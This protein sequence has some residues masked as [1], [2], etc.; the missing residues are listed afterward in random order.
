MDK[1]KEKLTNLK[2]EAESWQE[3]YEELKEQM[4]QLEQDNIQKENEIKSLTVKNQQL[5]QEVEKL[6]DQIKETKELAE[7]STTLKSHNENFNKRTKCWKKN[8]KKLIGN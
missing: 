8:W 5:D 7:E 6:E 3:K 4:K 2:L 1:V